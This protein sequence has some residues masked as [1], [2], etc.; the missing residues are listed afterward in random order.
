MAQGLLL[1]PRGNIYKGNNLY[2]VMAR[3]KR[4]TK[5]EMEFLEMMLELKPTKKNGYFIFQKQIKNKRYRIK[6][7]RI[8]V[9]LHLNRKIEIW[10]HVHHKDENKENDSIENL[11][12]I[13]TSKFNDH[14]SLHHAGKRDRKKT[15]GDFYEKRKSD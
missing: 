10:E 8:I 13:D 6:R 2:S 1:T 3:T 4:L 15:K 12:V 14:I 5:K 11:E 9:Q 7:S